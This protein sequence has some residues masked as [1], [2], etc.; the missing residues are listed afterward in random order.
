MPVPEVA[1]VKKQVS[2]NLV[3]G[4]AAICTLGAVLGSLLPWAVVS[5]TSWGVRHYVL[6]T[7]GYTGDGKIVIGLGAV[8]AIALVWFFW[9]RTRLLSVVVLAVGVAIASIGLNNILHFQRVLGQDPEF[10][11]ASIGYGLLVVILS[12]VAL[13]GCSGW[14]TF[15]ID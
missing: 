15:R 12:G 4:V 7:A 2:P 8:G 10:V 14:L 11:P 5:G 13:A 9:E 1:L 3:I 6:G